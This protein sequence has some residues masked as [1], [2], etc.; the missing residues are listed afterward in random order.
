[1]DGKVKGLMLALALCSGCATARPEWVRL[2]AQE[3]AM[4]KEDETTCRK[5]REIA[6]HGIIKSEW[7]LCGDPTTQDSAEGVQASEMCIY[8]TCMATLGWRH[9]DQTTAE[10]TMSHPQYDEAGQMIYP[11][12]AQIDGH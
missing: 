2:P 4:L 9:V 7:A 3:P 11:V 5:A 10:V 8:R 12:R 1:M 6:D